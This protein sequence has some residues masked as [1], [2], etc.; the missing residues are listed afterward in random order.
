[1]LPPLI[2]N[3]AELDPVG[4]VTELGTLAAVMLELAS[5]TTAPVLAGAVSVTVPVDVWPE[6]I[7]LG[8]TVTLLRVPDGAG[9]LIVRTNVLLTPR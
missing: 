5:E 9:G 7:V 1:M 2:G 4:T 8:L 3:V 6:E